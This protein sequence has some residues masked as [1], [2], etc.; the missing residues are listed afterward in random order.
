MFEELN[1]TTT[2]ATSLTDVYQS[3]PSGELCLILRD[4]IRDYKKK[5]PRLSSQQIA[6]RFNMASSTF[7]R[8]EN[9]DIKTPSLDQLIKVLRGTGN[10]GELLGFLEKFYPEI[11]KTYSNYYNKFPNTQGSESYNRF[12]ENP[13][14]F[15]ILL[16]IVTGGLSKDRGRRLLR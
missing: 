7:N 1:T 12:I 6:K 16:M 2:P 8:I 4:R 10:L 14:Y 3:E 15:K 11:S 9:M 5:H 13:K